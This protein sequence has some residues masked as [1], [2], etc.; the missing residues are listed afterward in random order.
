MHDVSLASRRAR[1]EQISSMLERISPWK[2]ADESL[3]VYCPSGE[4]VAQYL[5]IDYD[6][7]V[8]TYEGKPVFDTRAGVWM[9]S[10][11]H[12][13]CYTRV[14]PLSDLVCSLPKECRL[15]HTSPN[16]E[17]V[18]RAFVKRESP[19]I[20]AVQNFLGLGGYAERDWW[21][22][23]RFEEMMLSTA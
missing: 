12:P 3:G 16:H 23:L 13:D 14:S 20:I 6:G 10:Q 5:A 2:L 22:H 17:T 11:K 7:S 15:S 8:Y 21:N 19:F 4:G 1:L 18:K 9:P